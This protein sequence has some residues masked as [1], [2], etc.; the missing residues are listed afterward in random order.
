M[1]ILK[2]SRLN[3]NDTIGIEVKIEAENLAFEITE[4]VT[5]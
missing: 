3:P 4:S 2:P 1:N 5:I